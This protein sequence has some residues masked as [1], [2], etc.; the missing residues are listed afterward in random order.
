MGVRR[1]DF[2]A[3]L[4]AAAAG[5]AVQRARPSA[6]S[7]QAL[8]RP[9][10]KRILILGGTGFVGP[11]LVEAA[12][13][14][15]HTLTLFNRG[16]TNPGLFP[17]VET[18]I[19]DR[20]TDI[21]R[22]KGRDWDAV[23]DTWVMLPKSVRAAATLLRDHVGQYLFVSTISVYKLGREPLDE[24]SPVWTPPVVD[25]DKI[26]S[27][28]A[29]GGNK[30]LAE[31]AAEEAMPGRATAIRAGVIVG[32]GDPSDRFVYWPLRM[33]RG[34]EVLVPGTP[35]DRMQLIDVRDLG[36]WIVRCIEERTVGT[37]NAVGPNDP[38]LGPVLTACREAAGSDA[39]VTWVD[40]K[41]LE[42]QK[43]G[44]W[45]DF[46]L[47]VGKDDEHAGFGHV[48]AQKA[49]AR[50]LRFRPTVETARAALQWYEAQPEERRKKERP[51]LTAEREAEL[52]DKWHARG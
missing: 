44:G 33:R 39:R 28:E 52:L 27:V 30:Q 25:P 12:R 49:I 35:E 6:S 8:S 24:S 10:K 18:I 16:K 5:C 34:G 22:L 42:E 7:G 47:V 1:R 41:W 14:R 43:V 26:D 50:G 46:P 15:G 17:D 32:P 11:A 19:G 38:T 3:A 2:L 13:A 51:G 21:D 31:K 20:R 23:V 9:A 37:Y 45:G 4:A 48:S 36:A 40:G 29:Y